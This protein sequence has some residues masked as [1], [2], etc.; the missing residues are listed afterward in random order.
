MVQ[1]S[2][3]AQI[4]DAIKSEDR[5]SIFNLFKENSEQVNTFTPFGGHTWLGYAAQLGKLGSVKALVESGVCINVGDNR[6]NVLPICCAADSG[7]IQVVEFFLNNGAEL[8]V[9]NS[10]R[11]PL[12][13]AIVGRSLEIVEKLLDTGIDSKV[14][15][16]SETMSNMD[17]IAFA[18]LRGE[19]D[20]ARMIALWNT[21]GNEEEAKLLLLEADAIAEKNSH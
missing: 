3:P 7:H 8:D 20:C 16:D 15:Y 9:S 13:A 2:I 18:L 17:A 5:E 14:R 21:E 1:K 10:I 4:V 6:E 19:H 11:N 12:F